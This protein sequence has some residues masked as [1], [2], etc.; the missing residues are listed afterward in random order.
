[1]VTY[2]SDVDKRGMNTFINPFLTHYNQHSPHIK[3][4]LQQLPSRLLL[5]SLLPH[6]HKSQ[7][8]NTL[9]AH[10]AVPDNASQLPTTQTRSRLEA[11][12]NGT[13]HAR[14]TLAFGKD[15]E[16]PES[17]EARQLRDLSPGM[18]L[19]MNTKGS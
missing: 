17:H 2:Q 7:L 4:T 12:F 6:L 10:S 16:S 11:R 9:P 3:D 19:K 1:M 5:S 14:Q 13:R 18:T 15:R 8:H